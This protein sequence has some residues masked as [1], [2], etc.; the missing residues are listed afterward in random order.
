MFN[1]TSGANLGGWLVMENW[2]FPNVLLLRLGE[3]GIIDNQEHDYISR[4]LTR[5]LDAVGSMHTH[6]NTFLGGNLLS[7][8]D[9]PTRLVELAAAGVTS[10]RI[11]VGYWSLQEPISSIA[12]KAAPYEQHYEQPYEQP[13][14]TAEGFVTG[15]TIY[16]R[17]AMR[18][19][20]VLGLQAVIDV[21]SL[22]GGAVANMGYVHE[23]DLNPCPSQTRS[24]D[25]SDGAKGCWL[26][27]DRALLSACRVFQRRGC[28][29]RRRR[30]CVA[31]SG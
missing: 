13:G 10:V 9:P 30:Q 5:G 18:W 27:A 1:Y 21:H 4:M 12:P 8:A 17:A 31:A 3:Q 28:V 16:L 7:D 22:P 26:V 29:G 2:L 14:L 11:P 15:A 20:R 23:R 6:W 24:L 25:T 19:L